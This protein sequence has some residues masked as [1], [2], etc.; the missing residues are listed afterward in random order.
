MSAART[1]GVGN[2]ES[3][4]K[5]P[6]P[7]GT[8]ATALGRRMTTRLL[9]PT[10]RSMPVVVRSPWLVY[11]SWSAWIVIVCSAIGGGLENDS[12]T[13]DPAKLHATV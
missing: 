13:V 10:L 9:A 1:T 2:E 4:A 3:T 12:S 5:P 6:S 11:S 8:A 7:T